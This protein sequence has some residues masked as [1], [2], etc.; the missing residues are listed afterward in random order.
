MRA[1]IRQEGTVVLV[2]KFR[3][4]GKGSVRRT[5]NVSTTSKSLIFGARAKVKIVRAWTSIEGTPYYRGQSLD[6]SLDRYLARHADERD[7]GIF[8]G[9]ENIL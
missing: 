9:E 5:G 8:F 1:E 7:K 2:T 6:R 3:Y 4:V